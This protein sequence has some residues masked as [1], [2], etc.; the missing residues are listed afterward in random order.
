MEVGDAQDPNL[1]SFAA[2]SYLWGTEAPTSKIE[3]N[4]QSFT[5]T[6]TLSCA[7]GHVE[8]HWR[9]QFPTQSLLTF[10][11]LADALCI[12]EDD[13][14]VRGQ[15]IKLMCQI[16]TT[17]QVVVASLDELHEAIETGIDTLNLVHSHVKA[18]ADDAS[19]EVNIAWMRAYPSLISADVGLP[20]DQ[21]DSNSAWKMLRQLLYMDYWRYAWVVQELVLAQKLIFFSDSIALDPD[22][23]FATLECSTGPSVSLEMKLSSGQNGSSPLF[24]TS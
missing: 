6:A 24:G 15:Q 13:I 23:L 5:I 2:L 11:H 1:S 22:A 21:F 4:G 18:F 8:Q 20:D 14:V 7:L 12:N 10:H 19:M 16:C 3:A 9:S 17:A